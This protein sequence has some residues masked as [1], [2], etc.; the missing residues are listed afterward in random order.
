MKDNKSIRGQGS[1]L[2]G[3]VANAPAPGGI[4][5]ALIAAGK[6]LD[7]A[8]IPVRNRVA[9]INVD[10]KVVRVDAVQGKGKGRK[11][12]GQGQIALG[13]IDMF[14]IYQE[15]TPMKFLE[16]TSEVAKVLP[17]SIGTA[18]V[19]QVAKKLFDIMCVYPEP[20]ILA[21]FAKRRKLLTRKIL[22]RV[23]KPG[24]ANCVLPRARKK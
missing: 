4:L 14:S 7:R 16:L 11:K 8:P 23:S 6:V 10:G 20:E 17:G 2:T 13:R 24:S 3:R 21:F 9:W 5:K 1:N 15:R 19:A 12:E 22:K 18:Q